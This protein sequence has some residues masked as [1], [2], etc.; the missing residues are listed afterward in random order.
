LRG[1]R[2]I[3]CGATERHRAGRAP[4]SLDNEFGTLEQIRCIARRV[5][6]TELLELPGCGHSPHRDRPEEVIAECANVLRH[7]GAAS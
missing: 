5:P 6:Q 2:R 7:A 3:R 4:A 1:A